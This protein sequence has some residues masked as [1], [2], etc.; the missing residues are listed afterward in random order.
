VSGSGKSEAVRRTLGAGEASTLL[1]ATMVTG[2]E[3]DWFLDQEAA[4]TLA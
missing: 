4:S 3:T 1:P 2:K